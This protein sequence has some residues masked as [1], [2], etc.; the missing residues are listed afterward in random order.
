MNNEQKHLETKVGAFVFL[1]LIAIAIMAI[2]FGRVGQGLAK[3]YE[4][5]VEFSNTGGLLKNSDVL[6]SGAPVGRVAEKPR[7]DPARIGTVTVRLLIQENMKIPKGSSFHIGSSGM[8]GDRFVDIT[9]PSGFDPAK[10]NPE[11]PTQVIQPG[12]KLVGLKPGGFEELTKKGEIAMQK[13]S[14]NLDELKITLTKLQ[15]NVLSETNMANLSATFAS[16]KTTGD[17]FVTA[18]QGIEEVVTGA[19]EAVATAKETMLAGK[20]TMATANTTMKTANEAANDIR[21][22][23]AD[24]RGTIQTAQG[25]L[26]TAEAFIKTAQSGNGTIPMLLTNQEVAR[27]L[28][29]LISNIRRH[30]VLFYRDSTPKVQTLPVRRA[31][32]ARPPRR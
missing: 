4:V 19:K 5:N 24:V 1:G 21:A 16:I 22:A 17:N 9:P 13:L 29:A 25:V 10:F 27:N 18:S 8:M 31:E 7:V 14:D 12:D 28:S 11:D 3:Y 26:K 23:I 6:L 20:E 2:Q 30:G 15:T 32:A